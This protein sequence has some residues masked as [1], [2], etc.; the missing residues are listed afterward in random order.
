M[1]AALSIRARLLM[2]VA[3]VLLAFLAA[4][5]FAVQQ[6][7]SDSVRAAYYGRLRGTIYLL[8]AAAEVD[9]RGALLMPP[10]FAEPRLSL[11][12]SGL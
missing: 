1:T 7:H 12:G 8:L 5:G 11:P 4:A 9:E 6:A 10:E 2:G 3:L